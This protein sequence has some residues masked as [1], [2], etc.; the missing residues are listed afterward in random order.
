VS[1]E[2][3]SQSQVI[4]RP[5]VSRPVCLGVRHPSGIRDQFF[6]FFPYLVLESYGFVDVGAP[7]LTRSRVCSFQ[8]LLGIASPAFLGSESHGTHKH[9][10]LSLFFRLSQPGIEQTRVTLWLTVTQSVC[11]GAEP[12]LGLWPDIISRL[13][14]SVEN[15]LS[16]LC[17]LPSLTRGRVCHLSVSFCS[18]LSVW[19]FN[20]YI[21]CV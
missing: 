21:S 1:C 10:L 17:G 15:L 3:T 4:L 19:T 13:K 16:C 9:I 2:A 18:N 11:L 12:T 8:F 6:S 5:T 14:V 20:I 7:S